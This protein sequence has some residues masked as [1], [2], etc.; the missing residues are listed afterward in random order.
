MPRLS[1]ELANPQPHR[2][3]FMKTTVIQS[4][5]TDD[6]PTWMSACLSSTETWAATN[7]WDYSFRGDDIFDLVPL[8]LREKFST[9][10]PL[11]ID[12]ARLLWARNV[13]DND[14]TVERV[15]WLDADVFVF[16][17]EVIH[18]DPEVDFA[19]GRQIWI[20]SGTGDE[21]RT[22]RQVHN[23]I[24]VINRSTPV[25]DFLIQTVLTLAGRHDGL[26]APQFLGPKLLTA[27]HNIVGFSVIDSV[28]MVSP[29]ALRDLAAVDGP[30]LTRLRSETKTPLGAVNLCSSYRDQTIDDVCCNDDL[31]EQATRTL[32]ERGS[33]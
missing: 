29:L 20:Q 10:I 28:G 33:F 17:P 1:T 4:Y 24:L 16:A 26:A 19:V 3:L 5:R 23:A 9:Q 11:Q 18:I 6:Q 7:N 15:I 30:A 13:L 21:F 31:F 8:D 22:Y 14:T 12:I 2:S 32:K 25:L 27:L